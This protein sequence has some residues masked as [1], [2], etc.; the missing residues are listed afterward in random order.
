MKVDTGLVVVIFTQHLFTFIFFVYSS[1]NVF[2][3]FYF[4][5]FVSFFFF[6]TAELSLCKEPLPLL[7]GFHLTHLVMLMVITQ[8]DIAEVFLLFPVCS[9]VSSK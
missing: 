9:S 6:T 1:E 4:P 5:I 2:V 3:C 7:V 8:D